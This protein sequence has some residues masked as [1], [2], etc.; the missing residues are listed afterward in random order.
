M[1]QLVTYPSTYEPQPG[2]GPAIY[3]AGDVHHDDW[4]SDVAV[5][6]LL[7][8]P[9]PVVVIPSGRAEGPMKAGPDGAARILWEKVHMRLDHAVIMVWFPDSPLDHTLTWMDL[10]LALTDGRHVV[11]GCH[12]NYRRAADVAH[13]WREFRGDRF[14]LHAN[15]AR[16]VDAALNLAD[17]VRTKVYRSGLN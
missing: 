10:I 15:L 7:Q 13:Y 4:Q 12:P 9:Q 17:D 1:N 2:D 8:S 6:R 3:V 14:P 11:A 16:T 5:P